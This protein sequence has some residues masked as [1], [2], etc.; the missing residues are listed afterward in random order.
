MPATKSDKLSIY[1][2]NV[3][4]ADTN[5]IVTP[6]GNLVIIDAVSPSKLLDLMIRLGLQKGDEIKH[7]LITHPHGDHYRAVP[8]LLKEYQV[9]T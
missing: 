4:Q 7:L 8:R 1:V 3:G 9:K 5:V 2:L 6:A